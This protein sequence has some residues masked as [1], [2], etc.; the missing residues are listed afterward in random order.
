MT[1]KVNTLPSDNASTTPVVSVAIIAYQ[2]ESYIEQAVLSVLD[3]KTNFSLEI[4]VADDCSTDRTPEILRFLDQRFP[5]RLT[6][7]VDDRNLG[8][9]AN[10]QRCRQF[11][12]GKYFAILEGDDYW[13]DPMKL[14]RQHD[15]MQANPTWSMCF[16]FWKVIYESGN[17]SP[18]VKPA[19]APVGPLTVDDFLEENPIQTMSVAMY[20][21]GLVCETPP[22]HEAIRIGDWA[23]HIMHTQFGPVGFVPEVLTAYRVHD[24]GL[25]SGLGT[26]ARWQELLYLF[27]S[28]ESH[29]EGDIAA[30][31]KRAKEKVLGDCAARVADLEKVERRYRGLGLERLSGIY[32]KLRDRFVPRGQ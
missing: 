32:R 28:L 25:W 8:L 15:A 20:R 22:W 5:G 30:K 2:H 27:E 24:R 31:M 17:R 19:S 9:S 11:A 10:I 14:Q 1:D 16:G 12:R 18:V 7:L 4:L 23:L 3:Q 29:F 13:I 26:F 6:F 21:Q